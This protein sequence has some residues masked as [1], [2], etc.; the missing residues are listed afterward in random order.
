M[1]AKQAF[2]L[3]DGAKSIASSVKSPQELIEAMSLSMKNE[4]A[5]ES[6]Y[7]FEKALEAKQTQMERKANEVVHTTNTGYGAELIPGAIQTTDFLDLAPKLNPLLG[8][9]RGFHGRNMAKIMEVPAIGELPL[10]LLSS[11]WTTGTAPAQIVAG[12]GKLPTDKLTITQKKFLFSVDISDEEMRYAT[13]LD[14]VATTQRKLAESSAR[15]SVSTIINGDTDTSATTNINTIDG[16]PAGTE[17]YLAFDGLIKKCFSGSTTAD[18]GTLAFA[19]FITAL[20]LL[21]EK[22]VAEDIMFLFGT[23]SHNLALSISEFSQQYINGAAS[24]V[25]TG[26]VPNFLGSDVF[27][28]RYLAKGTTAGKVAT[29]TPSNNSKGRMLLVHK[30]AVQYGYNGDY[31]IEIFRAPGFG[32]QILGYYYAGAAISSGNA[33]TDAQV[34]M[35]YNLS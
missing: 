25:M 22:A 5:D 20:N 31:N 16:T 32:W 2:Q 19:D 24:T 9:F 26:R 21:G 4:G 8:A 28:N 6:K 30:D 12:K 29:G 10:H 7:S 1:D 27:V 18:G 11:E 35:L 13:V 23:Y 14:I 15:T 3:K 17:A 34:A 33:G